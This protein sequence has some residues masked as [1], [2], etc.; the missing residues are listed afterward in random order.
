MKK[1]ALA[2]LIS[3]ASLPLWAQ[4]NAA[5]GAAD[6]AAERSRLSA[7]RA[8]IEQRFLEERTACYKK[9][10]V[11]DCLRESRSRRR[12]ETDNIK[13]Q[14]TAINDIQRQRSGAAEL[15]K[16]DQKAARR[17][18]KIRREA[19]PVDQNQTD[20]EQRAADHATS[21]AATA[22]RRPSASASSS[23]SSRPT[24]TSRPRPRSARPKRRAAVR[25]SRTSSV[26]PRST[27]PAASAR[28]PT[29][30]SRAAHRCRPAASRPRLERLLGRAR[31]A[32]RS[33]GSRQRVELQDGNRDVV[34]G[35]TRPAPRFTH[36]DFHR[37]ARRL[38]IQHAR[39]FFR[40]EVVPQAV[41][42]GHQ[43]V[44]GS[45]FGM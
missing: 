24:P 14:E 31:A 10:A 20:R 27:G 22:A 26:G 32:R 9:F 36:Q 40:A 42:A 19:R 39:H 8:V 25:V 43:Q 17:A 29:A 18:P 41:A 15:Q 21:R 4:S 37:I 30:A 16:L 2:L 45:I 12:T 35:A 33:G 3:L 28:T 5:S 1:I 44:A 7:E 13:R 6:L 23:R 34:A 11:E 38:R